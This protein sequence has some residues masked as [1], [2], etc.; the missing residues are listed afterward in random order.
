VL[1]VWMG[2]M[3]VPGLRVYAGGAGCVAPI[4]SPAGNWP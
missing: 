2:A 3:D 4:P 1:G